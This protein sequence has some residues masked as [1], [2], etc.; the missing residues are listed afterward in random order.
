MRDYAK[1]ANE[2]AAK[3][4]LEIAEKLLNRGNSIED[5]TEVIELPREEVEVIAKRLGKLIA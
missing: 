1:L 3:A 5:V 2:E 4:R